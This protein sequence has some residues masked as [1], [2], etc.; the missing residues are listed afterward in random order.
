MC[1]NEM[2]SKVHM[3]KHLSDNFRIRNGLEQEMLEPIA[4]ELCFDNIPLGRL[5]KTRCTEIKGDI[6]VCSVS[7]LLYCSTS[8]LPGNA[9]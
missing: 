1:L 8:P 4:F 3:V 2:Y 6:V 9:C 7:T 5:N